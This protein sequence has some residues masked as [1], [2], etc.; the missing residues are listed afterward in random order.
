M[1]KDWFEMRDQIR[2]RFADA[3]WIPLK[4]WSETKQGTY[5]NLGY[6]NE[7]IGVRSVAI[8]S[9]KREEGEK[10]SWSDTMYDHGVYVHDGVYKPADVYQRRTG[11]D[12]GIDLVMVQSFGSI[13][14]SVWHLNQDLV[15]ALGLL[16]E[17]NIWVCPSEGY[18][19]VVRLSQESYSNVASIKIRAEFLG[20]Y[21]AARSLVLRLTTYRSRRAIMD[22][23]SAVGWNRS[24]HSEEIEG[25]R[26]EGRAWDV[27]VENRLVPKLP[28][29]M[30]LGQM[31]ISNLTCPRWVPPMMPMSS[32][33]IGQPNPKGANFA[34]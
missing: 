15:M 11:E 12:F 2:R 28:Y 6:S 1:E 9:T 4:M 26:F 30:C 24:G 5:G 22:N 18:P 25:G 21:L 31:S 14:P 17:G 27:K 19:D 3:V 23:C 29:S 33:I 7:L 13:E 16:R 32:P 20:D 34:T 8:L 10:I